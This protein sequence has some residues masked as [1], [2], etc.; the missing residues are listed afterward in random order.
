LS[1][2]P[3]YD[4]GKPCEIL[5]EFVK[6]DAFD[7]YRRKAG[8]EEVDERKLTSRADDWWTAWRQFFL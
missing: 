7:D 8:I 6:T 3:P 5:V 2:V 4:P 1:A